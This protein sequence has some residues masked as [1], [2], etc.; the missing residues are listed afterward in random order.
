MT[1]ELHETTD[2]KS[3]EVR[4]SGRL[5]K[6]DYERFTP[7]VEQMIEQRGKLRILFVM[8][9]FHGWNAGALWEDVKFDI[10]HFSDI[11]RLAMVG[12]KKW[13]KGMSIFCKPFTTATIRYFER[14]QLAEA[15][16]WLEQP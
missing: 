3:V 6:A 5:E 15:A 10:K 13:Q 1:L 11:E 2:G 7:E 14:D 8:H 9:D 4:A 16:A 12:E